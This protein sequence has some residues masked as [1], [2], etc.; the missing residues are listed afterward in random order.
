MNKCYTRSYFFKKH[1]TLYESQIRRA[2]PKTRAATAATPADTI[3]GENA[4]DPDVGLG[5]GASTWAEATVATTETITAT[6]ATTEALEIAIFVVESK[7]RLGFWL[8]RKCLEKVFHS[9]E[10][11]CD[12]A[13]VYKEAELPGLADRFR[14]H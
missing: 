3:D 9:V 6:R 10:N 12:E 4:A 14:Q 7:R 1:S 11:Q 2:E 13:S 8:I 5:A